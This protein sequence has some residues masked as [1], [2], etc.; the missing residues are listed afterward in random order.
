MK[1]K[2]SGQIFEKY[3]NIKFHQNPSSGILV[4]SCGQKDRQTRDRQTDTDRQT[5]RNRQRNRQTDTDRQT[6]RQTDR[7]TDMGKPIVALR[8]FVK[9]PKNA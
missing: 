7:E 8:N 9:A 6:D 2:C 1:L 3:S 5:D 4:V